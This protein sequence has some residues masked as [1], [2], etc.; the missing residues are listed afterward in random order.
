[1]VLAIASFAVGAAGQVAGFM[2]QSQQADA[3]AE[4]YKRN[5]ENAAK[6]TSAR[7]DQINVKSIQEGE[8]ASDRKFEAALDAR[9]AAATAV[10]AAGEGGVSGLS[11]TALL[12]DIASRHGRFETNTD[13]QL[14]ISRA[15]LGGEKVAAQAGGQGQINSVPIPE[16]PNF[17]SALVGI[18]G[19]GLDAFTGYKQATS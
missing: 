12:G 11:V 3:Q 17:A 19:S 15:Y 16:K 14:Q 4:A 2:Q 9:R 6:A 13:K 18:F 10:T 8:A 1:M 5:A 7:Y